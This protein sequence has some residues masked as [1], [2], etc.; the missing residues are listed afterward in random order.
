M[1]LGS[2]REGLSGEAVWTGEGQGAPVYLGPES[3]I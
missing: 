3:A 2:G 1:F